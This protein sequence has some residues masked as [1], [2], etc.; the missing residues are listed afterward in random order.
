MAGKYVGSSET[1][2]ELGP[3]PI[4]I[5]HHNLISEWNDEMGQ[6]P[7]KVDIETPV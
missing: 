5:K 3:H 4:L 7:W 2:I 1:P 6:K